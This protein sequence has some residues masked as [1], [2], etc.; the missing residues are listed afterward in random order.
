MLAH[1]NPEAHISQ[2]GSANQ[3]G[4]SQLKLSHT[5]YGGKVLLVLMKTIVG[6]TA[7]VIAAS[8]KGKSIHRTAFG[9][10]PECT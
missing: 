10:G 6:Q 5:V 7:T 2:K 4:P 8:D 1:S 9:Q 3:A